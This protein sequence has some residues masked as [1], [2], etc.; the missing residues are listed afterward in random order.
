MHSHSPPA[1]TGGATPN[2]S[3]TTLEADVNNHTSPTPRTMTTL[4]NAVARMG[5]LSI[6][7]DSFDYIAHDELLVRR[8]RN[9][10]H[11]HPSAPKASSSLRAAPWM[12]ATAAPSSPVISTGFAPRELTP[13]V[14]PIDPV[15]TLN[16]RPHPLN[17]RP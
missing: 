8:Q 13:P 7:Q 4:I 9:R 3:P 2:P 10:P 14:S 11:I 5:A 16:P 6:G 1:S 12:L 17:P 15:Q